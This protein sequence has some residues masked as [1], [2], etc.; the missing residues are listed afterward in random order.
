MC[1]VRC[2]KKKK[3]LEIVLSIY[4]NSHSGHASATYPPFGKLFSPFYLN[5]T[6]GVFNHHT[7]PLKRWGC[8]P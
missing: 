7:L 6:G 4:N 8:D 3:K 2:V 1:T 5:D